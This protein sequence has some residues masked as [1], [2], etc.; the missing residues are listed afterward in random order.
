MALHV[1]RVFGVL[2]RMITPADFPL[3]VT[4]HDIPPVYAL[5]LGYHAVAFGIQHSARMIQINHPHETS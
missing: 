2:D 5:D 4:E 1:F 3:D